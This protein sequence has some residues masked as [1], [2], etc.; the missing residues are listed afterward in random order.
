MSVNIP[1]TPF[2]PDSAWDGTVNV[3]HTI[4]SPDSPEDSLFGRLVVE[5]KAL[6]DVLIN[7]INNTFS[8]TLPAS[9][10]SVAVTFPKAFASGVTPVVICDVP[11]AT[12]H[13]NT[14]KSNTG[15]T[16]HVGTTDIYP[17][18]IDCFASE[19]Q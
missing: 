14:N 19:S 5:V 8:F 7:R 12:S 2:F 10:S 11:Y 18:T 15:F 1:Y 16:F 6:E 9:Q 17:Q 13:W 3:H 4:A